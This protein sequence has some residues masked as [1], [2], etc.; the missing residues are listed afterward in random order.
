MLNVSKLSLAKQIGALCIVHLLN[1]VYTVKFIMESVIIQ[2]V[3]KL[4]V[5]A[6]LELCVFLITRHNNESK[7]IID[8]TLL[9]KVA[10]VAVAY[11]GCQ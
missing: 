7:L 9:T 4:S 6:T 1:V 5:A 10:L 2:T 3:I 8:W 11:A